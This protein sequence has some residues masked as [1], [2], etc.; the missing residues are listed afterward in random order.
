MADAGPKINQKK[1]RK[2]GKYNKNNCTQV[3]Y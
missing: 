1:K 2:E 3:W